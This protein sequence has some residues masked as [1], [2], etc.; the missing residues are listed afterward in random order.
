MKKKLIKLI[1]KSSREFI[2]FMVEYLQRKRGRELEKTRIR[3]KHGEKYG[4]VILLGKEA[5][6][7]HD[8]DKEEKSLSKAKINEDG[9]LGAPKKASMENLEKA[10][11]RIEKVMSNI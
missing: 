9:S 1:K 3:V 5:Y 7:I 6:I 8:I 2:K 10:V 4:E 11:T